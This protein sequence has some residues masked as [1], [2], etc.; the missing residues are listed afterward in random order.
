MISAALGPIM[1]PTRRQRA[2]TRAALWAR[3]ALVFASLAAGPAA[4][5]RFAL[6]IGNNDGGSRDGRLRH[7]ELDAQRMHDV[8]VRIGGFE[9]QSTVLLRAARVIDVRQALAQLRADLGRRAGDDLVFIYFSGHADAESL[10]VGAD[11]LPLTELKAAIATLPA[12]VRIVV[13]D[14]CQSGSLVRAKGGTPAPLFELGGWQT[15]PRGLALVASSTESELAQESDQL[16]GSLFTHYFLAGLR[17]AADGNGDGRVSLAESFEF[18]SRRTVAATMASATGPQ[19]PVFRFEL[20]GQQEVLLTFPGLAGSAYGR[21]VFDRPGW[22]FVRQLDQGAL[23][24]ELVSR[25]GDEIVLDRGRYEVSRRDVGH[26][27]VATLDV[28]AG[29]SL[30][31]SG[32]PKQTVAF[33]PVVRKGWGVRPQAYALAVSAGARSSVM[34]LGPSATTGVIGRVDTRQLS[35]EVRAAAGWSVLGGEVRTVRT[36]ELQASLAVLR[37]WDVSRFTLAL[38]G[39]LGWAGFSQEIDD[40]EPTRGMSHGAFVAPLATAELG[41]GNRLFLRLEAGAPVYV[42]R[43]LGPAGAAQATFGPSARV[44]AG[45][46]FLF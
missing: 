12:A 7:A 41:L 21:L 8:L 36:R 1:G 11:T 10:H 40:E 17:G 44:G 20:T 45:V 3:L 29:R 5:A 38:G 34:A 15:L 22:Y 39:E 46:G 26:V 23:V 19:H 18:A 32:V 2:R 6:V 16:G 43:R 42:V 30:A 28:E 13:V 35:L 33:G 4:A 9:R 27:E 24:T 25:A 14:A 31:L 37:A